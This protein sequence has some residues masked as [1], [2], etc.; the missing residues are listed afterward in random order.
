[1]PKASKYV[2]ALFSGTTADFF[3]DFIVVGNA[4]Y[5]YFEVD[6]AAK[7]SGLSIIRTVICVL[8]IIEY[9]MRL[10]MNA[11][12]FILKQHLLKVELIVVIVAILGVFVYPQKKVMWR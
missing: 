4:I 5:V 11:K 9:A 8:Y 7:V 3:V 12:D 2:A 6:D 10:A 1:M